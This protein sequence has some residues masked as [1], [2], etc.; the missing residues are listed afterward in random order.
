MFI[1]VIDKLHVSILMIPFKLENG[2]LS[3]KTIDSLGMIL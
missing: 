3:I 1:A 2:L